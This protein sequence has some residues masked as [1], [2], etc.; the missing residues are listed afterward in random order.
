M[1]EVLFDL[2]QD[3]GETCVVNELVMPRLLPFAAK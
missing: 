3:P 1:P 2:V